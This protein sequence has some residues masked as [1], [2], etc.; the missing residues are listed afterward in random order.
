MVQATSG[1]GA[2]ERERG[3]VFKAA[4]EGVTRGGDLKVIADALSTLPMSNGGIGEIC[5][6]LN[7]RSKSIM[8][9]DK[10]TGLGGSQ[11]ALLRRFV[12]QGPAFGHNRR[13]RPRRGSQSRQRS[14]VLT[15]STDWQTLSRRRDP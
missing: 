11:V 13:D 8:E 7:S 10:Q 9:R 6:D 3:R 15:R 5:S 14:T 2:V 12:P 4:L 1:V